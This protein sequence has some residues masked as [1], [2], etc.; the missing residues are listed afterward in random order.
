M[1]FDATLASSVHQVATRA[2]ILIPGEP[3]RWL[4]VTGGSVELD[5]GA[6]IR[7]RCQNVEVA[8][9][10]LIPLLPTDPLQPLQNE[11]R[12]WRGLL[13]NG[14]PELHALGTFGI[15]ET[16]VDDNGGIRLVV[17]GLDR[18]AAVRDNRWT[19]PWPVSPG[20]DYATA[21]RDIIA[22]RF[23]GA[24]FDFPASVGKTTPGLVFGASSQND[25]W[26]DCQ[27]LATACAHEVLVSPLG[28]FV[29]RPIA[30]PDTAPPLWSFTDG[31]GAN[32]TGA[33]RRLTRER[34]YTAVVAVS[35]G[36]GLAAPLRSDVSVAST[37]P[38][39]YFY[40]TGAVKTQAELDAVAA[41]LL[42]RVSGAYSTVQ[43]QAIPDPRLDVGTVGTIS[44]AKIGV[45]GR[46][47]LET[48]S[49]PLSAAAGPMTGS[50]RGRNA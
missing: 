44:R 10:T 48:L 31:A 27:E 50:V 1:T 13:V 45:T 5:N 21:I 8:D 19:R 12:L 37:R 29:L 20:T 23:A 33:N 16:S 46:H 6:A 14:E 22:N 42:T 26:K 49:I 15:S 11:V 2:E 38:R 35:E 17:N 25:P 30:D 47:V 7:R 24:E 36:T 32:L 9:E 18:S 40:R 43:F 28:R 3:T 41:A 4:P 39:T 34:S